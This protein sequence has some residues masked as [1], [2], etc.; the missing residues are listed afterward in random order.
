M[1]ENKDFEEKLQ[2]LDYE[3]LD[4]KVERVK[5]VATLVIVAIV[6]I[7]NVYGFAVDA[8]PW[9][10]AFGSILSVAVIVYAWWKNQN[11]TTE[12]AQSQALLDFLKE[13]TK[14]AKHAAVQEEE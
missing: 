7:L 4:P 3:S 2:E 6:N 11:V 1:E 14:R 12:A 13:E 9:L 5:A 10:N 8:E